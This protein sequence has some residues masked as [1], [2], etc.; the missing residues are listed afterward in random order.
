M[1]DHHVRTEHSTCVVR[2]KT[3]RLRILRLR[4]FHVQWRSENAKIGYDRR[5]FI[6]ADS[7][8]WSRQHNIIAGRIE[9]DG[10]LGGHLAWAH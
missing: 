3:E 10:K 7:S 6:R 1:S 5:T 9:W 8:G 2:K 4:C